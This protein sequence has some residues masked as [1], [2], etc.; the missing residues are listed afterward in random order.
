MPEPQ[1]ALSPSSPLQPS[2]DWQRLLRVAL[3]GTRQAPDA[4]PT[5]CLALAEE[6]TDPD[7]REKQALLAAG[8]LSLV[9]KAGYQFAPAVLANST[10]LPAPAE[11]TQ[12]LGTTGAQLLQQLLEGT[13]QYLLA[14]FLHEMHNHGRRVPHQFL[15]PLLEVARSRRDLQGPAALVLGQRG[16]WLATQNPSWQLILAAAAVGPDATTWETG[17]ISERVT[18][19]YL[20]RATTPAEARELLAATLPQEPAKNQQ[21]LLQTL[22]TGLTAADAP[23]LEQYLTSKNKEVRQ[24]VRPLLAKVPSSAL[25]E[26]VWQRAEPL[27]RVKASLLSKK[28]LVE[29]PDKPW[30]RTWLADGL[31]QHDSRFQ[32]DRATLLGQMLALI[33]PQRWTTHLNLSVA[34]LLDLAAETEW[35]TLLLTGW[36]EGAIL[37]RDGQ[38]AAALLEWFYEKPRKLPALQSL[39][40]LVWQLSPAQFTNL[41]LPLLAA[42]PNFSPDVRWLPLLLQGYGP[43]PESLTRRVIEVLLGSLSRPEQLH[44]LQY[45]A[46]QLFEH[47]ARAVPASQYLL[48][49]RGLEPL[50]HDVPYIHNSLTRLLGTLHFRQQLAEA[51]T[52]PPGLG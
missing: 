13:H 12:P 43:W 5:G 28:L 15:V 48:C 20:L 1:T 19:L 25:V 32:G 52:E 34:K 26:R 37:H 51:L 30:D 42:A 10:T 4:L 9:R 18:F 49:A 14:G 40:G 41:L 2:A 24:V 8:T 16:T 6:P 35:A 11:T 46:T 3:L 39:G 47:M 23:L 21:Q 44:R 17:S 36:A 50:L 7:Y 45:A 29:L 38:W 33:P 27:V 31:E 22:E